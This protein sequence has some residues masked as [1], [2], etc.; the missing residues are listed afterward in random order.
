[1]SRF[2]ISNLSIS[3]SSFSL[4]GLIVWSLAENGFLKPFPGGQAPNPNVY[5]KEITE[6][7]SLPEL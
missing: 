4:L 7:N 1:V 6:V 2:L 5:D 3:G